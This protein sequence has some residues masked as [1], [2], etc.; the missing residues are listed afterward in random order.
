[1]G[2]K[3]SLVLPLLGLW[4]LLG[5]GAGETTNDGAVML[6]KIIQ[7]QIEEIF[8]RTFTFETETGPQQ[9]VLFSDLVQRLDEYMAH[10][11][12]LQNE[13]QATSASMKEVEVAKN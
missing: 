8:P 2:D 5:G 9:R 1:M 13:Q 12:P 10:A 4:F 11:K 3:E 6:K 7:S